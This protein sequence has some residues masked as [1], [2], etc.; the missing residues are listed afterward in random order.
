MNYFTAKNDNYADDDD[1]DDNEDFDDDDE[2]GDDCDE[3]DN[4]GVDNV[5]MLITCWKDGSREEKNERKMKKDL[6]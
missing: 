1:D 3:D 6:R 2:D 4:K 5:M